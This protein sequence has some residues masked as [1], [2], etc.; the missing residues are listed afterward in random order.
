MDETESVRQ[1]FLMD[2]SQDLRVEKALAALHADPKR[3]WNVSE[4]AKLAGSSRS[5]LA[6][7]FIACLG[8]TPSAWL[9]ARRLELAQSLLLETSVG[10][11]EVAARTGYASEF[12]LS[13]AFKRR[14]GVAP[15]V[16][17]RTSRSGGRP[18]RCAA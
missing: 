9:T 2:K 17:R 16:F 12:A 18:I 11:A 10:L 8:V 6:R 15:G 4:L 5:N 14:F 7:L 13:R 1:A 3:R